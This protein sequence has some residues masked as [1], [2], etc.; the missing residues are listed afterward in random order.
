M[1]ISHAK[2][3]EPDWMRM[4]LMDSGQVVTQSDLVI[5]GWWC[6]WRGPGDRH[7]CKEE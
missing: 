7:V 3:R 6:V 5:R 1:R 2:W 4:F